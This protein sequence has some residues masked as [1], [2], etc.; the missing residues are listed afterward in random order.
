MPAIKSS[1]TTF[2]SYQH[3]VIPANTKTKIN[4]PKPKTLKKILQSNI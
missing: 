2:Y 3:P 1:E 4:N